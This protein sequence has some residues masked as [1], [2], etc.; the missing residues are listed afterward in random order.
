M[1]GNVFAGYLLDAFFN[2]CGA[3][4]DQSILLVGMMTEGIH[5][6][7]LSDRDLA[8][9]NVRYVRRRRGQLGESF[10]P[11]P[12]GFVARRARQVLGEAVD[13]LRRIA[14]A[15]AAGRHRRR[16]VRGDQAPGRRRPRPGRG[17]AN[18]P[19]A[20]TTRRSEL[21]EA[22]SVHGP[23]Q[24]RRGDPGRSSARTGTPPG[25]GGCRCR[26]RCRCR[27]ATRRAGPGRGRR[28]AAG[29]QDGPGPGDGRARQGDRAGLHVLHRLRP[30]QP[31]CRLVGGDR[32]RAGVPGAAGR[33][34]STC[35]SAR[36]WAAS[37]SWSGAC[38]GTDA[39]TVG[40]DAILNVKGHAGEKGLEYYREIRVVNLGAQVAVADLVA[41][42]AAEHAD[43]V[44]VSQVVTQRDAHLSNTREMSA[45]FRAGS[46]SQPAAA[47]GGRTRA[48]TRARQPISAWTR[49]SAAAPRP[50]RWP[51]T[52][53]TR[54]RR[55]EDAVPPRGNCRTSRDAATR[56]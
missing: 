8:L 44:L 15:G 32:G 9:E 54:S 48:S 6:P 42:A 5:T 39:H 47:G 33:R 46:G 31:P 40:I 36:R 38:I 35:G 18:A 1:T 3:M 17:G 10:R 50:A 51:A 22:G 14:L 34:R 24:S 55:P 27:S 52:W 25:T 20:T 30:R 12:D 16:D 43:A 7:F 19:R 56:A 21:L 53:C 4:T 28:A 26:S 2:L 23:V 45:A 41:R 13:L 37:W 11:E 29:G 49:S